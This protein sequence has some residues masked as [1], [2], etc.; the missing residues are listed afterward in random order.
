M[1]LLE[2]AFE[3][4]HA[5]S[6]VERCRAGPDSDDTLSEGGSGNENSRT[7]YFGSSTITVGKIK[8]MVEKGY[9]LKGGAHAPG[10]KTVSEPNDDKVVV[11]EDFFITGLRMPR[12]PALTDIL[13]HFEAQ[14]HQLTPNVVAHLSKKN[15]A[16]DN[17]RGCFC[18]M[19]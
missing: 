15:W 19:E 11:Y 2:R 3:E 6:N 4:N 8:E 18:E 5:A 17:F 7:C 1:R 13:L 14:L 10:M 9:F 12:H 16:V